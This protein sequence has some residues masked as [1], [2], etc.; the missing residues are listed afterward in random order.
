[1]D[2]RKLFIAGATGAV[3]RNVA[4]LAHERQIPHVAH[5]RP[6][7][8][9]SP[10][11]NPAIFNLSDPVALDEALRG[12]TTVL[13]LIGSKRARFAQG[14]T[15]ESSDIA[16]TRQL[17]EASRRV[18]VDHFILL[19]SVGAGRPVGAYLKAKARAEALVTKSGVPYTIF[20]PSAFVGE[21]HRTFPGFD[22]LTRSLKLQ[23]L[24]P[25]PVDALV[26]ALLH[27]A[28]Q[29]SPTEAVLEGRSLWEVVDAAGGV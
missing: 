8:D 21:G 25:I 27:V 3:G 17:V 5:L 19:S 16:T 9:P 2:A 26:R 1:M 11:R 29:R 18:G 22:T 20:R 7:R 4:K 24:R 28:M 6:G 10:Y 23:T 12:C 15:Y 14:D 13:Q